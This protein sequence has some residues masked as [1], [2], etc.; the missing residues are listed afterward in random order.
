VVDRQNNEENRKRLDTRIGQ[1]RETETTETAAD[2]IVHEFNNIL[3]AIIGYTEMA[4]YDTDEGSMVRYNLEQVLKA[5]HRAKDL[6]KKI[7]ALSPINDQD[8][9]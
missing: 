2:G 4:I 7:R 6:V 9:K 8:Q 5:G 1:A 3:G